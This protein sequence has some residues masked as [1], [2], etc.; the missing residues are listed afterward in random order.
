M[1]RFGIPVA[2]LLGAT[3]LSGCLGWYPQLA[4]TDGSSLGGISCP[5]A[6]VC[7]AVGSNSSGNALVEQTTDAGSQWVS[8]T[9][10]VTGLG[11]DA[12]SCADP[13][14]CVAVGGESLGGII[15]P[16]NAVLVTSD[17]GTT[18][19]ASTVP[20]VDGYLTSVS[21]PDAEHCWATS[22]VGIVG[23]STVI[24][25]TDGGTSWT[26]LNWSAPPLPDS[27]S[28][29]MSSQLTSIDC[30]TTSDCLAVGQ[31][32]Y[33]TT[34]VPPL[35][36]QGVV[37]TTNDGGQT[38]HTQLISANVITGI[39]CPSADDC[40]A[41]GQD[42]VTAGHDSA[43]SAY[44][45]VTHD[46]G[47]TWTVSTLSAG[48]QLAQGN[49]PAI[50]AISCSDA[51]HCVAAGVVFDTNK[52]ETPVLS[53]TD[54][55][56]IWSDQGTNPAGAD[57]ESVACVTSSS[58]WAVGFTS[59][60][61]VI[62]HTLNGGAASPTVT[63]VSPNQ[64]PIFGGATVSVTGAGFKFGVESVQFGAVA[65]TDMTVVSDSE[66]TVT[67]PPSAGVVPSAGTAVDV[68]V[69]TPLGTSPLDPAD[70]F[71]YLGSSSS[72][73][74]IT[75]TTTAPGAV[76]NNTNPG[77]PVCFGIASGDELAVAG[78]VFS[79][80]A[81]ASI[82]ECNG[83]PGQ[84]VISFMSQYMPVSCSPL[85]LTNVPISG[86]D[87]G[88]L[89]AVQPIGSGTLGPP[90]N[91]ITPTCT[92][93]TQTIPGCTTSGNAEADAAG[94]P[95]PPTRA[96]QAKGDTCVIAVRDTAGD[97]ATGII[98]FAQESSPGT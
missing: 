69:T 47:A 29:L 36:N 71:T 82:A 60:G 34:L 1:R 27:Q 63:G 43:Y 45:I 78:T 38:W 84:P 64:G 42:P 46:G 18:W 51:S 9:S 16:S 41:V 35:E 49:N 85:V 92:E 15:G 6:S 40:V 59:S 94:Y 89:S 30:T 17:G 50:N 10:G 7:F 91:G 14:H 58:C 11:L 83:D 90:A 96:Q 52:Y 98:L 88:D 81:I 87:K 37:S 73:P 24:V 93:G 65:A 77:S 20:S 95:C 67:V 44:R 66:L 53:T 39:S 28:D 70:Q 12:I 97:V 68:T 80:G 21:C 79:P 57:L 13:D 55:G 19:Q 61:S 62:V 4:T 72:T 23:T 25:S 3:L 22:A 56:A 8:D 32:T 26:D 48:A 5:S 86:Q 75:L 31:A 54:G 33:N 74:G 2:G 76:C